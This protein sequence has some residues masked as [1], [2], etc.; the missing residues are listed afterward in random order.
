MAVSSSNCLFDGKNV[1]RKDDI[2][3]GVVDVLR[4]HIKKRKSEFIT[5]ETTQVAVSSSN[6]LFVGNKSVMREEDDIKDGV[7]DVLREQ[8]KKM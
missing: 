1:V 8:N 4:E 6:C 2:K 7:V 3:V 5:T